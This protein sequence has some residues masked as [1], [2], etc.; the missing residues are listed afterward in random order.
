MRWISLCT[1]LGA[2][3]LHAA[4]ARPLCRPDRTTS[5]ALISTTGTSATESET[6]TASS[7]E[8]WTTLSTTTSVVDTATTETATSTD[9]DSSSTEITSTATISSS[10]FITLI[11]TTVTES[12]TTTEASTTTSQSAEPTLENLIRNGDFEDEVNVDWSTRTGD[13]VENV[14]RANSPSHYV[15]FLVENNWAVGG[16]QLN[17]TINGLSTAHLFRLSFSAAIFDSPAPNVGDATCQLEGLQESSLVGQW[18]LAFTSVNQYTPFEAEF[19]PVS[20]DITLTLRLRCTTE[21][22]VTLAVGLDDVV[23]NDIGLAPVI[24]E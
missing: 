9:V 2:A 15:Q 12:A 23:L 18:P 22:R 10:G 11:S 16:N 17:Q 13:I 21:N 6:A 8:T 5:S 20:G 3:L 19:Q 7:S 1:V 24:P 14:D 4:S